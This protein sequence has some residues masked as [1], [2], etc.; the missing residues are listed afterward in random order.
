LAEYSLTSVV[1]E[2]VAIGATVDSMSSVT[3][4]TSLLPTVMVAAA[5]VSV[6]T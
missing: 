6:Y 1:R 3:S 2:L 4:V 5:V